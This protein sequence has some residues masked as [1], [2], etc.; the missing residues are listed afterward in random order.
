MKC[1]A[2]CR[3]RRPSGNG[4]MRSPVRRSPGGLRIGALLVLLLVLL[5]GFSMAPVSAQSAENTEEYSLEQTQ[6]QLEGQLE[7]SGAAQLP[8]KLTSDTQKLMRKLGIDSID[9]QTI[10]QLK[11]SDCLSLAGAVAKDALK[12]PLRTLCLLLGVILLCALADGLRQGV[13]SDGALTVFRVTVLLCV[14]GVLLQP[15]MDC[16]Q[17]AA[18]SIQDGANFLISFVPVFASILTVSGRVV[19]AGAYQTLLF[20]A[21][22]GV[23]QLAARMLVPL[24]GIYL[25]FCIVSALAPDFQLG[26]A[27]QSVKT[28]VSWM[29]GLAVTLF[30]SFLGLQSFVASGADTLTLKTAKFVLGSAIPVVGGAISDAL[31][32]T[33][34]CIGLLRTSVGVYAVAAVCLTL[35]PILMEC[36]VWIVVMK[37]ASIAA[38]IMGIAPVFQLFSAVLNTFGILIAILASFLLLV[39]VTTTL[40]MMVGVGT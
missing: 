27:A 20:A 34:A 7:S 35:L 1:S 40:M 2:A 11:P 5:T 25:A 33:H 4:E 21:A 36:I 28:F 14:S 30:V 22:Q 18:Q 31:S 15:V 9:F 12:Q 10:L 16:I 3:P 29:L 19:S 23:A 17:R 8:Q 38:D 6:Q 13:T 39:V 26:K 24:L 32:T 37:L